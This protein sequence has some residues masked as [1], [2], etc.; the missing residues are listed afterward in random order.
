MVESFRYYS[1]CNQSA[2]P[3]LNGSNECMG[4]PYH[5]LVD[6]RCCRNMVCLFIVCTIYHK[7]RVIEDMVSICYHYITPELYLK[8]QLLSQD[9]SIPGRCRT[10]YENER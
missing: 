9:R 2:H 4:L 6:L 1:I 10:R 8:Y 3:D 7:R 5:Q